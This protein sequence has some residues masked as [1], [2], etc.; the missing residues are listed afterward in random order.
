MCIRE[1]TE[2]QRALFAGRLEITA[3]KAWLA[4]FHRTKFSVKIC[5][6]SEA[7]V[8]PLGRKPQNY[9]QKV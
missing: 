9:V 1:L 8:C 7:K 5:S 4:F 3:M 6:I 2:R